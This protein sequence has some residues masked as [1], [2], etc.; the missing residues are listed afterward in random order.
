MAPNG[1]LL[2]FTNGRVGCH[3][4]VVR[5]SATVTRSGCKWVKN[6]NTWLQ[7]ESKAHRSRLFSSLKD[8]WRWF[9][10]L[11]GPKHG[12]LPCSLR[13]I[14]GLEAT[15]LPKAQQ[16]FVPPAWLCPFCL[17]RGAWKARGRRSTWSRLRYLRQRHHKG[18]ATL[19]VQA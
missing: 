18:K 16:S 12:A 17:P 14:R 1:R 19:D 4:H 7:W 2:A 13:A 9:G 6:H 5:R 11:D 10:I 8:R 15:P 3:F